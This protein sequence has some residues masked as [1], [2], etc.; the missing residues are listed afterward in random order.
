MVD[1]PEGQIVELAPAL[2][3]QRQVERAGQE[4]K[5]GLRDRAMLKGLPPSPVNPYGYVWDATRTRLIPT[6]DWPHAKFI[7]EKALEGMTARRLCLELYRLGILSPRGLQRWSR[8][9]IHALLTNTIYGGRF[10]ALR[11]HLAEPRTRRTATYGKSSSKRR[12]LGEA[13]ELT[14]IVVQS[15]PLSWEQWQALQERISQNKRLAQR[16]AKRDY[17]LRGLI[18]CESH[19]RRYQGHMKRKSLE[20]VCGGQWDHGATKCA[21]LT[22][23]GANLEA[24]VKTVCQD[25]LTRP[26][27]L[28]REIAKSTGQVAATIEAI[29]KK[30]ADLERKDKQWKATEG[31]LVFDR[32]HKEGSPEAFE[33]AFSRLKAERAWVAEERDRLLTDLET[34]RQKQGAILGRTEARDRLC[35]FLKQGNNAS[36]R[37][38]FTALGLEI[39]MDPAGK[40]ELTLGI[41]IAQIAIAPKGSG[42][43]CQGALTGAGQD[44]AVADAHFGG[45]SGL[46]SLLPPGH[47]GA[48]KEGAELGNPTVLYAR[49]STAGPARYSQRA[50]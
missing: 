10:Y 25:I 21:R 36:W 23:D 13:H 16:N 35:Q 34:T 12:P 40:V 1:A 24:Q 41:P 43:F 27:V 8:S 39:R 29:E 30:L 45:S 46:V 14:Y 18:T 33:M 15:P 6:K 4:A 2:G 20:Y 9:G 44:P 3:K 47:A 50:S 5:D 37:E 19:R 38:V 22:L 26:E 28:E 31:Q 49:G 17:F 7:L 48:G 42:R 32:A 11:W